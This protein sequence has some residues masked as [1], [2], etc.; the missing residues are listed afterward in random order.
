MVGNSICFDYTWQ[1]MK[2]YEKT[3]KNSLGVVAV[4][5]PSFESA[6]V[7]VWVKTG[8]RNENEKISGVSHFLEHMA[9]KGGKKYKNAKAVSEAIDSI[10]GEFNAGTSKE[11]TNYYVR[12]RS[13][14]LEKAFDVLSDML[15]DPVLRHSD[16]EREKGVVV[17][18]IGMYEDTPM[19]KIWDVFE[20]LIYNGHDLG[21]DISGT[22]ETVKGLSREDISKYINRHYYANNMLVTV[23]G[24]V[25]EKKIFSLTQKYFSK[26]KKGDVQKTNLFTD[27]QGKPQ[28]KSIQKKIEQTH[29]IL[30]FLGARKIG[31]EERYIEG[32]LN[33][34][35]GKG[36]S[37]RLVTEVREKR[38]LAYAVK[39][40]IDPVTDTGYFAVYAGV[41]PKKANE[42]VK[43][44]L[45]QCYGLASKKYKISQKEL[46]K[47]KEFLKG[48]FALALED[49]RSISSFIGYEKLLIGKT[50]L[51]KEVYDGVD[52][53]TMDQV[54]DAAKRLFNPNK[55]NTAYIGPNKT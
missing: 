24:G 36:M 7:T 32:V 17:E 13:E 35:L 1:S 43:V 23:A 40:D 15:L 51:P 46:D 9:F 20:Q 38:G 28:T 42:T 12:V 39:S 2:Y 33:T 6:T 29:L 30:G 54:Y 45:D 11:W 44:I 48:H 31:H 50:R 47:A 37:S 10:G 41:D 53:V 49:T 52:R 55:L 25:S 26:L 14:R 19:R 34:I 4:P 22:K 5:L 18:E 16:I 27:N 21:R 8:S 3:L